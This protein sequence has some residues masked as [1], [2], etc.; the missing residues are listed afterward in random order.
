MKRKQDQE[1][2]QGGEGEMVNCDAF[3]THLSCKALAS[4]SSDIYFFTME[5]LLTQNSASKRA[6]GY[7]S[8]GILFLKMSA[9]CFPDM[10][11]K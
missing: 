6:S 2:T 1:G 8:V 7:F 5:F 4:Q 9:D 10:I 3:A 11:T